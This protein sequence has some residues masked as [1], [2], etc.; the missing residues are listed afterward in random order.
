MAV[1]HNLPIKVVLINNGCLGMVRQWQEVFYDKRY[2]EID[3]AGSPDWLKL[4]EA[5]GALGL[6][7]TRPD[8]VE[9]VLEKGFAS[10]RPVIMVFVC[11]PEENCWPMVPGGAPSSKMLHSVPDRD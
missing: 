6:R 3:L 10:K 8:E 7:A 4:A 9:S 11:A 2:S 5:Y 1:E